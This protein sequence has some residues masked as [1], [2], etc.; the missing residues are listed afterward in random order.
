MVKDVCKYLSK[1]N[2][3]RGYVNERWVIQKIYIVFLW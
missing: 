2:E 1:T 3:N